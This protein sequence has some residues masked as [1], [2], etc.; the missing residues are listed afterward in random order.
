M[1]YAILKNSKSG[2]EIRVANSIIEEYYAKNDAIDAN[3]F[4]DFFNNSSIDVSPNLN[5]Y[6]ATHVGMVSSCYADQTLNKDWTNSTVDYYFYNNG[7]KTFKRAAF[8]LD[9]ETVLLF[10]TYQESS[11]GHYNHAIMMTIKDGI[12]TLNKAQQLTGL[13]GNLDAIHFKNN[14]YLIA[15]GSFR[16]CTNSG[17]VLHYQT[18]D[19]DLKNKTFTLNAATSTGRW[20]YVS[21]VGIFKTSD[22]NAV[23]FFADGNGNNGYY[24]HTAYAMTINADGTITLGNF[25]LQNIYHYLAGQNYYD[26]HQIAPNKFVEV[27]HYN[28]PII[29]IVTVDGNTST[30]SGYIALT[31]SVAYTDRTHIYHSFAKGQFVYVPYF[32]G[33]TWNICS[34]D[35]RG[36]APLEFN[37]S[38]LTVNSADWPIIVQ[39]SDNQILSLQRNANMAY[40][41]ITKIDENGL[42]ESSGCALTTNFRINTIEKFVQ[43]GTNQGYLVCTTFSQT[44]GMVAIPFVFNGPDIKAGEPQIWNESY[45]YNASYTYFYPL[46]NG[47]SICIYQPYMYSYYNSVNCF[48]IYQDGTKLSR[49]D[50]TVIYKDDIYP[51]TT[52]RMVSDIVYN[53]ENNEIA[54]LFRNFMN[55]STSYYDLY[56]TTIAIKG[57]RA[58]VKKPQMIRP[59]TDTAARTNH[60]AR[61]L[62]F[63]N[64][65]FIAIYNYN[66][67]YMSSTGLKLKR[68]IRLIPADDTGIIAGITQ[69]QATSTAKGRTLMLDV[70]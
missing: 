36:T 9:E 31:A 69:T 63:P 46:K 7:A 61:L 3:T 50:N 52:Q 62:A 41:T 39:V 11:D 18:L 1:A 6:S 30:R 56:F 14:R 33:G 23:G 34:V 70:V 37:H 20:R 24:Y 45:A 60:Y 40:A 4:V 53:E 29:T 47:Y 64:D 68:D 32:N 66:D 25:L 26:V 55:G 5:M 28:Y 21:L 54:L 35:C 67:N 42:M 59:N 44:Y 49:G 13:G 57:N 2:S 22:T 38:S 43:T 8:L 10:M 27:T 16:T 51:T 48:V 15:S 65:Q 12:V 58:Y 17:Y 19:V